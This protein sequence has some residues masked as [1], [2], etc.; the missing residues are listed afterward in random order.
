M[1][2][3][4]Y[5]I[6]TIH[7]GYRDGSLTPSDVVKTAIDTITA[8]EPHLNAYIT[9]LENEAVAQAKNQDKTLKQNPDI[10]SKQ[11]LFGIP[12]GLK[13]IYSTAGIRT[14]AGSQLLSEYIPPYNATVVER[15]I[16]AGA[17]ILGKNNLDAW[18][19][20]SSGENSDHGP[21][22]NPYDPSRVPGG[23]SSGSA[24]S[25]AA[26][27]ALVSGGT[28]TGGSIRLPASYCN[29]VGI[30]PTYGRVSRYGV[31]A[32]ASSLD[33]V[34]HF[35]KTIEDNARVLSVT[36]GGDRYD[37]TSWPEK[38]P[39]Y[40]QHLEA[41]LKGKTIGIPKEFYTSDVDP[42]ILAKIEEIR[43]VLEKKGV[44][45]KQMSLP[46][47][48]YG[49]SCYY[50]ICPAELSSN[51]ARFD[52]IRFG[53]NRDTFGP[54]AKRRI[55]IGT[56][57]LSTGYADE[58][59]KKA[60]EVRALIKQEYQDAF[61][62]YDAIM[63]PVSASLPFQLGERSEDPIQM[64]LSDLMTIPTNIAGIPAISVPAGL[65]NNLPVG[66]QFMGNMFDEQ[67]L[68]QIGY[69]V[70]QETWYYEVAPKALADLS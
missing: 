28:D 43:S 31:I 35:S 67:L 55:M 58:Y 56:H 38:P 21:T 5:S 68:Y 44:T 1:T 49:L 33:T 50:V 17:I 7:Q 10:L 6:A 48:E 59:Y 36:A 69:A 9:T 63:T 12:V 26:G 34:G 14:T 47:T 51:L 66:V 22:K 19:H 2:L 39:A 23:S 46:N 64:Y 70:E 8:T 53:K 40:H 62:T 15:Y 3:R 27:S 11:P 61:T 42:A 20:G 37:A 60:I 65:V 32:M 29:I 18:A 52:G 54:E 25:V 4:D 13:D 16:Q 41:D 30:K 24:T 57:V 45:F